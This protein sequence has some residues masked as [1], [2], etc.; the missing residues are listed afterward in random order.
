IRVRRPIVELFV[1]RAVTPQHA[2]EYVD[3]DPPRGEAGRIDGQG[4]TGPAPHLPRNGGT[5]R[6]LG[7]INPR[8]RD[9]HRVPADCPTDLL[10]AADRRDWSAAGR[11][12]SIRSPPPIAP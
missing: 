4:G 9:F 6:A 1:E 5:Q 3:G 11:I 12:R 7:G 8:A 10:D 2:V